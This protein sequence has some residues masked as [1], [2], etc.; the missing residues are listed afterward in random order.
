V[1]IDEQN[2]AEMLH[3]LTPEPPRTVTVEDVAIRLANQAAP[4]RRA[5]GDSDGHTAVLHLPRRGR[6]RWI[7]ALAAA[8]VLVVVGTSAGIAVALTSG[9]GKPGPASN[10]GGL[11]S[12]TS[13]ASTST[14]PASPPSGGGTH[15]AE[16]RVTVAG[17]IW[18]AQLINHESLAGATLVGSGSS[19]YA[20]TP[21][22]FLLRIDPASGNI[23]QQVRVLA[24]GRPMMADGKVWLA[25]PGGSVSGYD[26]TTLTVAV[27]FSL[28]GSV[29]SL[30]TGPSGDL[31]VAASGNIAVVDPAS[32][33]VRRQIPV[34]SGVTS[35][36]ISPDGGTLYVGS[37]ANGV[38]DLA[39]YSVA[40]GHEMG[41]SGVADGGVGD[42]LIATSGG[43]WGTIGTGM[44]LR[45]WFA[46]GGDLG[47]SRF[48]T[49][50]ENGGLD[51]VPTYANG[52]VWVGGTR[53]LQCLD[54]ATASV[55]AE[56]A[57]PSDAGLP[58]HFGS[59]AFAGGNAFALYQDLHSQLVGVAAV[60]PPSACAG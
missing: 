21:D 19:L 50:G 6:P 9:H 5:R 40:T 1:T 7:P 2:L 41:G 60:T 56:T 43:V 49:T 47:K 58:E 13:A 45:T 42:N 8:S 10:G 52:A 22:G 24:T 33:S 30:A 39:R 3:R 15:P 17:G 29:T 20:V 25:G 12:A 46:P 59:V 28:T 37:D 18:G 14:G 32:G 38:F 57:I 16:P 23:L 34:G 36:A 48:V 51:S 55:R 31:Y 35:V 54:P 53:S 27:H 4:P 11:S 26:A 44:T